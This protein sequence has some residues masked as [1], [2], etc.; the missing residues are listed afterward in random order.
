MSASG[1]GGHGL[2][3]VIFD[4]NDVVVNTHPIHLQAWKA[5]L[6]EQGLIL[7]DADR[8][9]LYA[10]RSRKDIL[11]HYQEPLENH[12]SDSLGQFP[13]PALEHFLRLFEVGHVSEDSP[14]HGRSDCTVIRGA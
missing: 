12:K 1:A 6:A 8:S 3:A 11:H 2:K 7:P 5:F 14:P 4:L 9:F 10:G 13:Q